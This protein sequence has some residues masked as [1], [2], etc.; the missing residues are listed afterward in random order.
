MS[1]MKSSRPHIQLSEE[2]LDR[3]QFV[4]AP[5]DLQKRASGNILGTIWLD[6]GRFQFP[7]QEW[8]DFVVVVLA[9]WCRGIVESV[10]AYGSPVN[11]RFM[12][13]PYGT[14]LHSMMD[15]VTI[16]EFYGLRSPGREIERAHVQ[17]AQMAR[18]ASAAALEVANHCDSLGWELDDVRRLR[19]AEA[20]MATKLRLR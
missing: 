9:W 13:G 14:N 19:Q 16:L 3:I 18:A 20:A 15:G 5:E 6:L 1:K 8:S 11:V 10:S 2:K 17:T 7:C 4:V 12:D